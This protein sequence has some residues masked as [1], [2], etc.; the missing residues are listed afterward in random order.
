MAKSAD[1]GVE[2]VPSGIKGLDQMIDGG[3]PKNSSIMVR[4]GTGTGKTILCLQ[5][6]FNG[7]QEQ[8]DAGVF[9]SFAESRRAIH[10]HGKR[11]GWDLEKLEKRNKLVI[12]RY[13]PHE[14]MK[15]M[16]EGGGSIRDTIEAIGT[17]RLV[18]DSISAYEMLFEQ[19]YKANESVLSLFELLRGWNATTLVTAETPITPSGQ[20]KERVGFLSDGI[21]NLYYLRHGSKRIR[22][23]EVIKMRDTAHTDEVKKFT[24]GKNGV[25]ISGRLNG[26]ERY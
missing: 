12:I 17:K 15:V 20:G 11:F 19:R 26:I 22:A 7:A 14:V 21:I 18:I 2:R 13:E 6:L 25:V 4:G 23:L 16:E 10:D 9:I 8:D 3:F 24:I 1:D 5:Y